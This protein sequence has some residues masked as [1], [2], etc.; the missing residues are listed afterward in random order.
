[1]QQVEKGCLPCTNCLVTVPQDKY[2]A[3]EKF[4]KFSHMLKPGL[5]TVG[6][7]LCGC[8]I[9]FRSIT[10]R[11]EQNMV[12]VSTKTKDNVFVHVQLDR[13]ENRK[14]NSEDKGDKSATAIKT[15]APNAVVFDL[16]RLW[17]EEHPPTHCPLPQML[18]KP[19]TLQL[20]LE[21]KTEP[22]GERGSKVAKFL[23][24]PQPNW[25]PNGVEPLEGRDDP[26]GSGLG[27]MTAPGALMAMPVLIVNMGGEMVYILAQRL[28]AQQIPS[29]K[30]QKVLCDVV[31]T[32]YYPRFIEEL[33][34][35]QEIYS[36]QS[37]RQIFDRLAHSSIMRLNPLEF[38][39][40]KT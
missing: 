16:I 21:W 25:G 24:N 39:W 2:F 9:G 29:Q 37:T 22:E 4:G 1:M 40:P 32:M 14:P 18:K 7:D 17:A 28:Q 15:D 23:P 5:A 12:N 31:R 34:K 11:T 10:S 35:P 13:L 26:A 36:L 6:C 20:P 19:L 8:C 3:V 38:R 30:G 33:F 27:T